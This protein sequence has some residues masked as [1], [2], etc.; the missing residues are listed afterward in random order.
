MS[1]FYIDNSGAIRESSELMIPGPNFR[2]RQGA[3]RASRTLHEVEARVAYERRG[4][5]DGC[6]YCGSW[7]HHSSDC[8]K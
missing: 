5:P 2:T 7:D 4:E 8:R 1:Y 6:Y 3:E